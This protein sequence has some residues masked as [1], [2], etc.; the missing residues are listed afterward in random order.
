MPEEVPV[1]KVFK[2]IPEGRGFVGKPSK[3]CFYAV[4]NG[5]KKMGVGG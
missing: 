5:L 3:I 4:E 2:N 1:R